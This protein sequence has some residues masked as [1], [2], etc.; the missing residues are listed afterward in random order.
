[1]QHHQRA[2]LPGRIQH[3]RLP[4]LGF[5]VR[6]AIYRVTGLNHVL[7]EVIPVQDVSIQHRQVH[8]VLPLDPRGAV[9]NRVAKPGLLQP[10]LAAL[11]THHP[12]QF[13]A[14]AQRR[15]HVHLGFALIVKRQNL[16]LS[17]V[18]V[19]ALLWSARPASRTTSLGLTFGRLSLATPGLLCLRNH[20]NEHSVSPGDHHAI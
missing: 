1:M 17:V 14:I 8:L 12:A 10:H 7:L 13:V 19:G 2:L 3:L 18:A 11:T 16:G 20:R 6:L 5:G 15:H 4:V 9:G